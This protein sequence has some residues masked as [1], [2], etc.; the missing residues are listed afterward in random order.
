[1][2]ERDAVRIRRRNVHADSGRN[3]CSPATRRSARTAPSRSSVDHHLHTL[4]DNRDDVVDSIAATVP[5][6]D[7]IIPEL[8]EM[9]ANLDCHLWRDTPVTW[10][11][12]RAS[13]NSC[14]SAQ[15]GDGQAAERAA[16]S[17]SARSS[18]TQP[19][20]GRSWARTQSV[21]AGRIRDRAVDRAGVVQAVP[22]VGRAGG[23]TEVHQRGLGLGDAV[24]A[25]AEQ[26]AEAGQ[27]VLGAR[28]DPAGLKL[29]PSSGCWK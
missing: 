5:D 21:S 6:H 11:A 1:M 25:A 23:R 17:G 3:R 12:M 24:A 14:T 19:R 26:L 15:R 27:P 10:L 8:Q 18:S 9:S 4:I 7:S 16:P 13:L 28:H 29:V 2:L 20:S 22:D